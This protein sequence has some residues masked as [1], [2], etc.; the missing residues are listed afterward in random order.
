MFFHFVFGFGLLSD[1]QVLNGYEKLQPPPPFP[2]IFLL[3]KR[4]TRRN[5]PSTREDYKGWGI[6][7]VGSKIPGSLMCGAGTGIP[8]NR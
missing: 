5:S 2:S 7:A 3:P 6:G 1:T 4:Q 8:R